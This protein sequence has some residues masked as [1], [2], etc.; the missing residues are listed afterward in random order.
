MSILDDSDH[1]RF[2]ESYYLFQL[3]RFSD[4]ITLDFQIE[5]VT[6]TWVGGWSGSR[7]AFLLFP[8]P[9]WV[10]YY[11]YYYH[12]YYYQARALRALGLLLADGAPTVGRGKTL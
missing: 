9:R 6:L 10:Y 8:S 11:Y 7:G 12:Y 2:S 1:C 5:S 3:F 4:E